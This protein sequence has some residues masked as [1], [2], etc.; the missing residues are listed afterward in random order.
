M[1]FKKD[2]FIRYEYIPLLLYVMF[3]NS[4]VLLFTRV[5]EIKM[6][7]QEFLRMRIDLFVF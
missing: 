4:Y 6:L 2:I 7:K 5:I 1:L 3:P